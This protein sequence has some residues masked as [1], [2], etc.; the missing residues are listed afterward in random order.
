MINRVVR[1]HIKTIRSCR[2]VLALL[3]LGALKQDFE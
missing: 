3:A 1:G 2:R